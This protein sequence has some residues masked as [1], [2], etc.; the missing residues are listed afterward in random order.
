MTNKILFVDDDPDLLAAIR[1]NL[2][3]QFNMDTATSGAEALELLDRQGPYAVVVSDMRMPYMNGVELL[4]VCR[5]RFPDVVRTM[6]TDASDQETVV[7][8]V[9]H[10]HVF[11]FLNKPCTTDVLIQALGKSL[12]HYQLVQA[13]QQMMKS[14]LL[15]AQKMSLVG[16]MAAGITHD[17]NNILTVIGGLNQLALL[18]SAGNNNVLAALERMNQAIA[19]GTSL[20]RQL[21]SLCRK[22][23]EVCP[24]EIDLA[25][26]L[27]RTAKLLRPMLGR[28]ITVECEC[29]PDLPIL[30][31]DPG[32]LSQ[33][34][35][36]L[37][38][39]ARDAMPEGGNLR[40]K[41]TSVEVDAKRTALHPNVREGRFICM[42]V[43]DN[44]CGM[45]EPTL[46]R[47]FEPFFT[48][49]GPVKGTGL[50]MTIVL[51][52]A[53]KHGGWVE[54]TSEPGKGAT[55]RVLLP[56][57]MCYRGTL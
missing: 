46:E 30:E 51:D 27:P 24:S 44:G 5:E 31:A 16:Q 38:V 25:E 17:F 9:N 28:Q 15:H 3:T 13:Q 48:T 53:R 54:A 36:N 37:T 34:V 18:I 32:L 7:Q 21:L 10:G 19:S 35:I 20:T 39:N 4:R 22:Q 57:K 41:A 2:Y 52:A 26:F 45:D 11:H 47:I 33:I 55:F 1:R 23:E 43:T 8:A 42:E 14:E 50:G 6:L 29:A 12:Q 49:K 40:F 56:E